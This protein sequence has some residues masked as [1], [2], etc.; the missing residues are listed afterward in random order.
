MRYDEKFYSTY[1]DGCIES[2]RVVAPIVM[3]LVSPASVVDVGCGLGGWLKIFGE[4]GVK[5]LCGIDGDHIDRTK[6]L[7]DPARFVAADLAGPFAIT[8]RF[9]LALCV[10]VAE[11]LPEH[12]ASALVAS[13]CG[14]APVILFSAAVPGQGGLAHVNERWPSYWRALFARHRFQMFDSIRPRIRD[15]TRVAWYYRQ[16]LVIFAA[17]SWAA[18]RPGFSRFAVDSAAEPLEWVH[19]ATLRRRMAPGF[20]LKRAPGAAWRWVR[21]W[22]RQVTTR[23]PA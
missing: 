1:A 3:D 6:L 4:C 23:P 19:I 21:G 17:A 9:D 11:H 18:E 5:E 15:D 10:E 12:R 20:L 16:N 13:L 2:A 14:A 8:G 7:F 22:L